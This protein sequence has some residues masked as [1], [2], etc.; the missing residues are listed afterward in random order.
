[1]D[2]EKM[3]EGTVNDE[4][5]AAENTEAT[6]DDK[7]IVIELSK[8]YAFEGREYK[9]IDLSGLDGMTIKDAIDI[10][11]QLFSE[12]QTAAMILAETS[13]AFARK[14]AAKASGLPIEFF[15]LMPRNISRVVQRTVMS[16]LNIDVTVENHVMTFTKPYIF[17]GK[18]YKDIDLKNIGELTSLNESEAE[19]RMAAEGIMSMDATQNYFYNCVIASMATGQPEEF[20][21]GL[22]F[23]ELLK[24]KI[25]VNDPDFFE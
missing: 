24:F 18:A 20:F 11:K 9:Q 1:M 16:Y 4:P 13:T 2:N 8:P 10:Q 3:L 19:N 15:Q 21:M 5:V 14:V 23:K 17:E 25:A 6:E 22:P 7:K 12:K